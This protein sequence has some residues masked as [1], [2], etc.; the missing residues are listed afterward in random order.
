MSPKAALAQ[1][2]RLNRAAMLND[3]V[4][5]PLFGDSQMLR[6]QAQVFLKYG[7]APSQAGREEAA[8][9]QQQLLYN[10]QIKRAEAE[11]TLPT[12]LLKNGWRLDE[13]NNPV[14]TPGGPNDPLYKSFVAM[15][16]Q[17][18]RDGVKIT[19]TRDGSVFRG[20]NRIGGLQVDPSTG[21]TIYKAVPAPNANGAAG[22]APAGNAGPPTIIRSP[23]AEARAR[24]IQE[25]SGED[26]KRDQN[27]AGHLLDEGVDLQR[28]MQ[29]Q[30]A[31]R[32]LVNRITQTGAGGG[33]RAD[34]VNYVDTYLK[35][36]LGDTATNWV[37]RMGD[38]PDASLAQELAK[39]TTQAAGIQEKGAVGARGSLG[40]T[41]LFMKNNPGLNTQ[42][43]ANKMMANFLL[44]Q[45][46]MNL[47]Y[48]RGFH[49]YVANNGPEYRAGKGYTPAAEGF[50][51]DWLNQDHQ[52]L[53]VAAAMALSGRGFG[54]T[55]GP[56]GKTVVPGWTKLL[57]GNDDNIHRVLDIVRR[58]DPTADVQW[59]D[60][61]PH[62]VTAN[63]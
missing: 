3:L 31:M 50:D 44:A 55:V 25:Q 38:L 62:P 59:E 11:A 26:Y 4:G 30:Y 63:R 27:D 54:D 35:P 20:P 39:L 34:I 53:Y 22:G 47:D 16:E 13:N 2:A 17:A 46:Q 19:I 56:D 60:G 41:E 32:D 24:V 40:L 21:D 10:P 15:S 29:S 6:E 12:D 48:V 28:L 33:T 45:N 9:L 8:R 43:D 58:I 51:R 57:G 42:P 5:M 1:A 18:A 37:K 23:G 61:Q 7:L 52:K 14:P 49:Q 36:I